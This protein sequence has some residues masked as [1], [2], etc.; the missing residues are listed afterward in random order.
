MT[1]DGP[2]RQDLGLRDR[3]VLVTGAA[4]GIGRAYAEVLARHGACVALHDA[5]VDLDGSEADPRWAEKAAAELIGRGLRAVAFTTLLD[6]S[7]SC[8]Q[9]V[10]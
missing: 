10:R 1:R 6:R 5:G 9:L 2:A 7:D 8:R 3:V 4:R